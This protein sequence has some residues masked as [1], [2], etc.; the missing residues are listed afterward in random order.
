MRDHSVLHPKSYTSKNCHWTHNHQEHAC[1]CLGSQVGACAKAEQQHVFCLV[2][3]MANCVLWMRFL[4]PLQALFTYKSSSSNT[5]W[6]RNQ[7]SET[8]RF[9]SVHCIYSSKSTASGNIYLYCTIWFRLISNTE[10]FRMQPPGESD[11]YA[12]KSSSAWNSQ[13]TTLVRKQKIPLKRW[14]KV[15]MQ[16]YGWKKC[17]SRK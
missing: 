4:W 17:R 9:G 15:Q 14:Q 7:K 13:S 6:Q 10:H 8:K 16:S 3:A 11:M 5:V 1:C 2:L 12:A